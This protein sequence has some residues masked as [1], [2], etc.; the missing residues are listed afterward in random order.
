VACC[1]KVPNDELAC[2]GCKSDAVY[3]GCRT[4]E[5]R[6]CAAEKGVAHC[7]DC[8]EYPCK[9]Y[10]KWQSAA[11]LLPHVRE[12]VRNLETIRRDG[13]DAWLAAQRKRWSCPACGARFSWYQAECAECGRALSAETYAMKGLRRLLCRFVLPMVYRKGKAKA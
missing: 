6:D 12:S 11:K 2:G 1:G 3:A 9:A 5:F 13:V 10:E 8:A 7:V 4:C